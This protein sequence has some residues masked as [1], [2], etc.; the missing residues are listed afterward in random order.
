MIDYLLTHTP[1]NLVAPDLFGHGRSDK[2]RQPHA[3]A[4]E[5]MVD[6]VS[7][8]VHSFATRRNHLVGH[9]IGSAL[10]MA[11]VHQLTTTNSHQLSLGKLVLLGTGHDSPPTARSPF[12]RCCN[13]FLECIRPALSAKSA[14][15]LYHPQFIETHAEM[16]AKDRA[17]SS[18]NPF[19]VIRPLCLRMDWPLQELQR[20]LTLPTLII[21]VGF[22]CAESGD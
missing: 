21:Q 8:L 7:F 12:L 10:T 19:Y 14:A 20:E 13:C 11:L 18:Q 3:Y 5:E 4:W 16:I 1:F 2:W 22:S 17:V 9:S 15:S 6:D